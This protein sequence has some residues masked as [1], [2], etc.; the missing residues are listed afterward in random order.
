MLIVDRLKHF[1][2]EACFGG[3]L[4]LAFLWNPLGMS[5]AVL[6]ATRGEAGVAAAVSRHPHWLKHQCKYLH[7]ATYFL[8]S[9]PIPPPFLL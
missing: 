1:M 3:L 8:T 7:G 9:H 6:D 2:R 4:V 5:A